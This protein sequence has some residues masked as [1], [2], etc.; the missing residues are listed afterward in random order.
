M[1]VI[2]LFL[3]WIP[4]KARHPFESQSLN[5]LSRWVSHWWFQA[6][7]VASCCF[8][9]WMAGQAFSNDGNFLAYQMK[10]DSVS[11]CGRVF[12]LNN[13]QEKWTESWSLYKWTTSILLASHCRIAN[14][15][16]TS[17]QCLTACRSKRN[18]KAFFCIGTSLWTP[19]I[20]SS[21]HSTKRQPKVTCMSLPL[22]T[23]ATF[24]ETVIKRGWHVFRI[25]GGMLAQNSLQKHFEGPTNGKERFWHRYRRVSL[26][27]SVEVPFVGAA[28]LKHQGLCLKNL[29]SHCHDCPAQADSQ[30]HHPYSQ[31]GRTELG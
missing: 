25:K 9:T 13:K 18:S 16:Q 6:L 2:D 8:L 30:N 4:C 12:M 14:R 15:Q 19:L 7:R 20:H 17:L 10:L 21:L 3:L 26:V 29:R 24:P 11:A 1:T 27:A 31:L 22:V 5:G 23:L 28:K